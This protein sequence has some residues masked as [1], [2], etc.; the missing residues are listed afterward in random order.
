MPKVDL[1][2]IGNK[3]QPVVFEYTWKDVVLYAL[4][5]GASAEELA[6]V[7][8]GVPGGLKV[9]PSFV[10][11]PAIRA[12]PYLGE[13]IDWSLMLHGEHS[14]TLLR[15]LPPEGKI[16]Q[17]GEVTNI[18]DK[19]KGAVYHIKISGETE[20]G[21]RMYRIDWII[22]YVGAG[23]FGGDPGPK[24]ESL[25]PPSGIAPDFSVTYKVPNNQAALYRLSGDL[26][27]LHL[28][29]VAAKRGGFDRPILHGLCTFGFATR[30]IVNA[31]LEGDVAR[32]K[33][34]KAR[35]SDVVYP[36]ENLTTNGWK[37][38]DRYLIQVTSDR[39]V[40][41]SNSLAKIT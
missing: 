40:V 22:F 10:V 38:N 7:Y 35:F 31:L 39:K 15:P 37:D 23:G 3:S 20:D 24:T 19:G 11:V 34:F 9:L 27:P 29:P 36:G 32:F 4:G 26:N 18:F 12:F 5:V 2:I 21:N 8:E 6:F 25:D 14:I 33:E 28:D 30:A 41:I 1:S 13:D 16:V 17:V